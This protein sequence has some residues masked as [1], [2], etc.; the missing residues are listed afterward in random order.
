MFS[1]KGIDLS[2]GRLRVVK[3]VSMEVEE[4]EAVALLGANGTG[5]STIVNAISGFIKP[6]KGI[7]EYKGKM[8]NH[9]KP[10]EIVRA[11][12]VQ[13]SQNRDLFPDLTVRDNLELGAVTIKDVDKISDSFEEVLRRF[14][15]LRERSN[16][17]AGVLSG[18]EQQMVAIARALMSK[19]EFLLMDEPSAGL[20]PLFV[21]EIF[22]IIKDLK[23]D[24]K[25]ILIV[26]HRA[27]LALSVADRY[28]IL[29]NGEIVA[30]GDTTEIP[31]EKEDFLRKLIKAVTFK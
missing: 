29:Q 23:K 11:G 2:Y 25:T 19:P 21:K 16:Q 17:K 5:K 3:D 20:A 30:Q 10:H 14:P 28:Y 7:I 18:G 26:E 9:L 4:N 8:I 1:I 27:Y 22:D 12:I 24:G 15:R 31:E 13:I 6:T